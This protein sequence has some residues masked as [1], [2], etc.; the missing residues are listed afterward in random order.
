MASNNRESNQISDSILAG[1]LTLLNRRAS[2]EWVGTM[3]ELDNSLTRV[4]GKKVPDNWPASPSALRVALNKAVNRL[5]VR[6][7]AVKFGRSSDH[8]RTRYVKFVTN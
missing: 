2:G 7:V 3:S 8:M 1:I 6:K 5:R 4:L